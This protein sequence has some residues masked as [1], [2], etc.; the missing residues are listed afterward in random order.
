MQ[1]LEDARKM[2][3]FRPEPGDAL[4]CLFE[5]Q[6]FRTH[7]NISAPGQNALEICLKKSSASKHCVWPL[8]RPPVTSKRA[9]SPKGLILEAPGEQVVKS[10]RQWKYSFHAKTVDNKADQMLGSISPALPIR[11]E[12]NSLVLRP[13]RFTLDL[14]SE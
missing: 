1:S 5:L 3:A 12:S 9:L 11:F 14:C 7:Q 8:R 6:A 4:Q 13:E 2:N 10:W